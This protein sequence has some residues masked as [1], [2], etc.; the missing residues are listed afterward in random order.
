MSLNQ[1][2]KGK[3]GWS[4]LGIS[5]GRKDIGRKRWR[6][7]IENEEGREREREREKERERCI[8]YIV[9]VLQLT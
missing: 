4:E 2:G 1:G 8:Q 7:V 6:E 9:S 3:V 5:E